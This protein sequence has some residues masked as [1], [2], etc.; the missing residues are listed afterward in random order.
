MAPRLSGQNYKYLK[1]LLSLSPV[2]EAY[3]AGYQR[4]QEFFN[5]M[6]SNRIMQ[7][8]FRVTG[9]CTFMPL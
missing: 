2:I 8:I 3:K 5:E 6:P 9:Q 7:I 4:D 1:F